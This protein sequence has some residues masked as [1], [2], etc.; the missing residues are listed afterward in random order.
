VTERHSGSPQDATRYTRGGLNESA[1][2]N[3]TDLT[4]VNKI[5]ELGASVSESFLR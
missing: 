3:L 5:I 2:G 4:Y 1:A